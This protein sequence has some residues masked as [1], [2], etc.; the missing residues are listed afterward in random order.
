MLILETVNF[1]LV[2]FRDVLNNL[3]NQRI[4]IMEQPIVNH[5]HVFSMKGGFTGD[6][7]VWIVL[8]IKLFS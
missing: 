5:F 4:G 2:D 7:A 6:V 8:V 1:H 3:R